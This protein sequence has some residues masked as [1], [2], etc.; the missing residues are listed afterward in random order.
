MWRISAGGDCPSQKDHM[1]H[2]ADNWSVTGKA[3][4]WQ[5]FA[6]EDSREKQEK[7]S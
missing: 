6:R 4:L 1:I 7:L 2:G 5:L 3:E